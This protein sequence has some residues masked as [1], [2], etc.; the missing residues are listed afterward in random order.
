M[1]PSLLC[2]AGA[3]L[4][5]YKLFPGGEPVEQIIFVTEHTRNECEP[6]YILAHDGFT[7]NG[8]KYRKVK[9]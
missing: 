3:G 5:R 8:V 4:K 6:D 7:L 2:A 1:T 9:E